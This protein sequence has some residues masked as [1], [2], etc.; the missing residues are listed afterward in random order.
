MGGKKIAQGWR[1]NQRK[2][3]QLSFPA[4][5]ATESIVSWL[6]Q[7][8]GK[9]RPPLFPLAGE[10]TIVFELWGTSTGITHRI[11]VPWQGAEYIVG[12]LHSLVPGIR[13]TPEEEFPR[14]VWVKAV[15]LGLTHSARQLD[16]P[17]PEILAKSLLSS[18]QPLKDD[19]TIIVQWVVAPLPRIPKPQYMHARSERSVFDMVFEGDRANRDEV[20]DRRDKLEHPNVK[21]VLRIGTVAN[22]QPRAASLLNDVASA[23]KGSTSAAVR[24]KR[25]VV[26]SNDLQHRIEHAS[27]PLMFPMQLSASELAPLLAWPPGGTFVSGLPPFLS[28]QL[29]PNNSIPREG[30]VIG[31]STFHGSERK[32]AIGYEQALMHTHILGATGSGKSALAAHMARQIMEMGYGLIVM[33]TEG[34]LYDA[35]LNY[36][37]KERIEDVVLLDVSDRNHPVGFNVLDQGNPLNVIDQVIDLF[38]HKFGGSIWAEEYIYHGLRTLAATEGTSFTDLAALLNPRTP[39]EIDWVDHITRKLT[40]PELRRWWQRHD[41]RDRSQQQLRADPVLSRIWQLASRPELRYIMGQGKSSIDMADV[42]RENKILLVNLKGVSEKT[43]AL[44]ATLLMNA[45]WQAVKESYK[46]KPSY[47]ILDEFADFMDLPIDTESML[48]QSRKHGVGLILANQHLTQLK[49]GVQEAVISNARNKIILRCN[50]DDARMYGREFGNILEVED[51]TNLQAYEALAQVQTGIG[52]SAPVSIRT[53]PAD[54]RQ[55]YAKQVIQ[56]SREK[57]SRPLAEVQAEIEGR[58]QRPA[59]AKTK[60][61]RVGGEAWGRESTSATD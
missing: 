37:P 34:N 59:S 10:P 5:L 39:E 33:E 18:I 45:T 61:P 58:H 11:K 40:D 3:Y 38:N 60:R 24:F 15:E 36:V 29:P 54:P 41:N 8:G 52:T 32:I 7:I 21:A 22:T 47:I 23:L 13:L 19:E 50:A 4:D 49:Q 31:H 16:I 56:R 48:A 28:R 2:T 46:P 25:R 35:V 43:G 26:S 20:A 9:L 27:A 57:Y 6:R 1:D 14:R 55:S 44:A 53:Y 51:F 42:L 17:E 30:L 12:Q